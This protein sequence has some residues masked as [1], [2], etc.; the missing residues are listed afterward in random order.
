MIAGGG[1]GGRLIEGDSVFDF[2]GD[3]GFGSTGESGLL[4][5]AFGSV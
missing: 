3:P 4:I 5:P 1:F 2:C